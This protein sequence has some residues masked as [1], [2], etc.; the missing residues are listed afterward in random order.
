[1]TIAAI[2]TALAW[3]GRATDVHAASAHRIADD[4]GPPRLPVASG[5]D[6]AVST[7]TLNSPTTST[8]SISSNAS[9][10]STSSMPS[11]P[12]TPATSTISSTLPAQS[13]PPSAAPARASNAP[14]PA[15][16]DGPYVLAVVVNGEPTGLI[17]P[18]VRRRGRWFVRAGD[19]RALG[20]NSP[21]L[22]TQDVTEVALDAL[23]G[24]RYAY[25]APTQTLELTVDDKWLAPYTLVAST[26]RP[27]GAAAT[28][29][30]TAASA[31]KNAYWWRT[32]RRRGRTV[33]VGLE[34]TAA[35]P[36]R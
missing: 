15:R 28:S 3:L 5:F 18:F 29:T 12:S 34:P 20:L 31:A 21:E 10:S 8:S 27:V 36:G 25:D 30:G 32:P 1:M 26:A 11:T 4:P 6:D 35:M 9:F 24:I 33:R 7:A 17:A 14:R 2:V 22:S 16:L 19:L 13:A 23:R